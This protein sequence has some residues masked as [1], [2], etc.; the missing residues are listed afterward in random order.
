MLD[1]C[2]LNLK[3]PRVCEY[4]LREE[5]AEGGFSCAAE[6]REDDNFYIMPWN[7]L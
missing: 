5:E 6:M 1:Y 2:C 3:L 4:D 7:N